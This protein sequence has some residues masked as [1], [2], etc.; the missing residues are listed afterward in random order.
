LENPIEHQHHLFDLRN[1]NTSIQSLYA[2][3]LPIETYEL[4]NVHVLIWMLN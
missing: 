1:R 2:L 3:I 4:Y